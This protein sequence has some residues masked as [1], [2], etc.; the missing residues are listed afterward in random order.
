MEAQAPPADCR[1]CLLGWPVSLST[2]GDQFP[3]AKGQ[4]ARLRVRG[5]EPP[6]PEVAATTSHPD[7]LAACG[8][9]LATDGP[10]SPHLKLGNARARF[11]FGHADN[12]RSMAPDAVA[13]LG[14]ALQ[15]PELEAS[16]E[17]YAGAPRGY[18]H[19]GHLRL[20]P[21]GHRAAL[22]GAAGSTRHNAETL[23]PFTARSRI[24]RSNRLPVRR[25]TRQPA[26]Q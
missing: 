26:A 20:Q 14:E 17:I 13:R 10:D 19:G 7:V 18:N 2:A 15:A 5:Y 23:T 21:G 24:A 1:F 3:Q 6:V 25:Q 22:P 8:S 12:D 11:V 16:N 9:G 4:V